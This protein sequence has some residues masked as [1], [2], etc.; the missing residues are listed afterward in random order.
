MGCKTNSWSKFL[1]HFTDYPQPELH[2]WA[3]KKC[4]QSAAPSP[5]WRS[6]T[7]NNSASLTSSTVALSARERHFWNASSVL[8]TALGTFRDSNTQGNQ[9]GIIHA[10]WLRQAHYISTCN[11]HIPFDDIQCVL[12]R[13]H[14]EF[15]SISRCNTYTP[16]VWGSDVMWWPL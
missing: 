12:E 4:K 15:L 13:Y 3:Y 1:L 14:T 16:Q 8:P 5:H 6:P 9:N 7:S 10:A 11:N 2:L